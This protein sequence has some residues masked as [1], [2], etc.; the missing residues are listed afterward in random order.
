MHNL[1]QPQILILE[2]GVGVGAGVE[3]E[4]T[5]RIPVALVADCASGFLTVIVRELSV[6][7]DAT[8]R[9]SVTWVGPLYATLFTVTPVRPTLAAI[10]LAKPV[11][12][13]KKPEPFDDVPVTTTF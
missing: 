13:S 10:R 1:L 11:P 5:L 12:G 7:F 8:K 9:S 4:T 6:A 2:V 3:F